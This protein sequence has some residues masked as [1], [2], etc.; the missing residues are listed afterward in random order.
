MGYA[1]YGLT[2]AILAGDILQKGLLSV[3]IEGTRGLVQHQYS[4][5]PQQ[6]AGNGY[7][8]GLAFAESLA[9]LCAHGVQPFGQIP[10][11]PGGRRFKGFPEL[12]VRGLGRSETKI[13]PYTAAHQGR[14]FRHPMAWADRRG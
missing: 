9:Y 4:S 3:G 10:H 7:P 11:E 6:R 1:K 2:A 5:G 14:A 12:I 8:L 13:L